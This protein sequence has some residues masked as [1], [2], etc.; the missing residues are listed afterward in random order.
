MAERQP[1]S[2]NLT[3]E[4]FNPDDTGNYGL[5]VLLNET[6]MDLSVLDFR[7]NKFLAVHRY[8]F[9]HAPGGDGREGANPSFRDFLS[10][11]RTTLPWLESTFKLVKIAFNG[12]KATLVP[13]LLF[14]PGKE[15]HYYNFNYAPLQE[16]MVFHDHILPLDVWQVYSVPEAV[17]V[18]VREFFPRTRM[19]HASSLLIESVW[20]NYKNRI[21][22]PHVFVHI[23]EDN[24]DLMIFDGRLMSYFN[25]FPFQNAE[26]VAYYLIFVLEQLNFN[27]ETV[28]VVLLGNSAATAGLPALLLRYLRHVEHGR[29]NEAYSYSYILNQLPPQNCFTLLNFFSC[30]L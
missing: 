23:R 25:S 17:V 6:G 3:D 8:A 18:A 11:I 21:S 15:A 4:S 19:I 12:K 28:P 14:D 30:G 10:E 9:S 5:A 26:E 24:F 20:I 1:V 2:L 16:E 13:D 7:R 27:P 29:R 22:S